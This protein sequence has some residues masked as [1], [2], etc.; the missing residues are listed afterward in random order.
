MYNNVCY[1]KCKFDQMSIIYRTSWMHYYHRNGGNDMFELLFS[2]GRCSFHFPSSSSTNTSKMKNPG[3]KIIL[4]MELISMSK[5]TE[6]TAIRIIKKIGVKIINILRNESGIF[7]I[8][9]LVC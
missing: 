4:G 3:I 2:T 1:M 9:L 7:M 5:I 6:I 8:G